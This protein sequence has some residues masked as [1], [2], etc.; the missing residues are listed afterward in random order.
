MGTHRISKSVSKRQ[1]IISVDLASHHFQWACNWC[2]FRFRERSRYIRKAFS[3]EG[4]H[5]SENLE[6]IFCKNDTK[7]LQLI[8]IVSTTADYTVHS[9]P[10]ILKKSS[11]K[12]LV[13]SHKSISRIISRPNSNFC[14]FKNGQKSIFQ[15]GK[16]LK[17]P[18]MQF[19]EKKLIYLISRLF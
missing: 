15:L 16:S 2:N 17:L 9:G 19:H 3:H 18:K 11:P 4:L 7:S 6:P 12:K 5:H 8:E 1:I 14:N 10:E 13:K